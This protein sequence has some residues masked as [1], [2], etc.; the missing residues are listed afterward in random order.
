MEAD[1]KLSLITFKKKAAAKED[2]QEA[3]LLLNMNQL[4]DMDSWCFDK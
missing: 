3:N 1:L 4:V 2:F